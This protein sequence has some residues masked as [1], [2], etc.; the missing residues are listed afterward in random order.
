[1]IA[2]FSALPRRED[3]F[4]KTKRGHGSTHPRARIKGGVKLREANPCADPTCSLN[5]P[6]S[7]NLHTDQGANI[8]EW[9]TERRLTVK[10]ETAY[11]SMV[12]GTGGR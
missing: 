8:E 9:C 1:M 11:E 3:Y 4:P 12:R 10:H 2:G 5:T 6:K 7:K